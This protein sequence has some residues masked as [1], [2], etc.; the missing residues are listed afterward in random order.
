[1]KYL[2]KTFL[3]RIKR[4]LFWMLMSGGLCF[5][6][7]GALLLAP[8]Q[9]NT[10]ASYMNFSPFILFIYVCIMAPLVEELICRFCLYRFIK[11]IILKICPNLIKLTIIL[12]ACISSFVFAMLHGSP[13]QIIYAFILGLLFCT[14]Y[15]KESDIKVPI[16]MHFTSNFLSFILTSAAIEFN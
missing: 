9:G 12:A 16:L 6:I 3:R 10:T 4:L 14:A 15:E 2:D 8:L 1:M 13:L 7:N 5:V 11:W